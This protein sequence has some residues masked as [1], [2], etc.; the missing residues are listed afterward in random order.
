MKP[1]PLLLLASCGG[2]PFTEAPDPPDAPYAPDAR[3]DLGIRSQAYDSGAPDVSDAPDVQTPDRDAQG[4]DA[5]REPE[6][7]PQRL[8]AGAPETGPG[9]AGPQE[10][11]PILNFRC[12]VPSVGFVTCTSGGGW[13]VRYDYAGAYVTCDAAHPATVGCVQGNPCEFFQQGSTPYIGTCQ[14]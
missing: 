10:A 3:A 13:T 12:V 1:W 7:S 6:A 14:P 4:D 5:Y 8:D 11:G 9:D 2:A